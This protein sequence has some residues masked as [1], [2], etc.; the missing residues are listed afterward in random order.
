M[1]QTKTKK[2]SIFEFNGHEYF[3]DPTDIECIE[4]FHEALDQMSIDEK[5]VPKTGMTLDIAKA[6]AVV[7]ENF[8]IH[9]FGENCLQEMFNGRRS[10]NL[11]YDAYFA[12]LDY[13]KAENA[14]I[15]GKALNYNPNRAARRAAKKK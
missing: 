13:W 9:V 4:R 8:F 1:S 10:I 5:K 2:E 3:F 6:N 12:F 15:E 7:Y 14:R 11:Y